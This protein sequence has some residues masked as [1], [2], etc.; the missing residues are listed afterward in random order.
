MDLANKTL[1]EIQ[2]DLKRIAGEYGACDIVF[3]DIESNTP[4]ERVIKV[5]ELCEQLSAEQGHNLFN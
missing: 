1:A 4:D 3:A 2:K 5:I